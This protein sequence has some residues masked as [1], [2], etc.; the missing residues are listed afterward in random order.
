MLHELGH[1][2]QI[3]DGSLVGQVIRVKHRLLEQ[4]RHNGMFLRDRQSALL[5]TSIDHARQ[6]DVDELIHKERRHRVK[7]A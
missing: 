2:S 3:G 4:W 1:K 5:Q 6:Q 7:G